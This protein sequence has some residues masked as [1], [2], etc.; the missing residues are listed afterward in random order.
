[1]DKEIHIDVELFDLPLG[2]QPIPYWDMIDPGLATRTI[3]IKAT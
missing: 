3:P 2:M 1:M